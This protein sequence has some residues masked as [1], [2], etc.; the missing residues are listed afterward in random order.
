MNY[1][2]KVAALS[3]IQ[4]SKKTD[5]AEK[6]FASIFYS[7]LMKQVFDSQNGLFNGGEEGYFGGGA[8]MNDV[9]AQKMVEQ[10]ISSGGYAKWQ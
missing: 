7:E 5:P 4:N 2:A 10:L 9:F 1:A 6:Q 3:Y 8:A